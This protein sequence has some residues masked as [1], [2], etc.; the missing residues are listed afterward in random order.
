MYD[1]VFRCIIHTCKVVCIHL[2]GFITYENVHNGDLNWIRII[3]ICFSVTLW[4]KNWQ[5]FLINMCWWNV[6]VLKLSLLVLKLTITLGKLPNENTF[7]ILQRNWYF[8]FSVRLLVLNLLPTLPI[9]LLNYELN[10]IIIFFYRFLK[11]K[12][13]I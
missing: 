7:I 9:L 12:Y 3:K 10:K 5:L 4:H 13:F 6:L 2:Y 1:S 11:Y 8:Y